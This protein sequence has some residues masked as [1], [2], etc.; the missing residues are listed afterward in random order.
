M[1]VSKKNSK[2]I[3]TKNNNIYHNIKFVAECQEHVTFVIDAF[4]S[5]SRPN[6]RSTLAHDRLNVIN[7]WQYIV[8]FL[9]G[10]RL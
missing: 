3:S 5:M 6:Y 4:D 1:P 2:Q 9:F 7:Y 10:N 8:S